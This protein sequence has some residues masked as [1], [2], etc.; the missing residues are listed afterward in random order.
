LPTEP[1]PEFTGGTSYTGLSRRILTGLWIGALLGVLAHLWTPQ[2]EQE[3]S[4][5]IWCA[6]HV[7][8]PFGQIFL[9]MI[10]MVVLPLVVSALILGISEL[11]ESQQVGRLGLA[12]LLLT[13]TLS[14]IAVGL[15]LSLANALEPGGRLDPQARLQLQKRYGHRAL[16]EHDSATRPGKSWTQVLV[17]LLPENPLQEM[18]GALDGSSKGNGMLAVM[19][20]ALL[21]GIALTRLG[22]RAD[23]LRQLLDVLFR[24]SM[25]LVEWA[26]KL[27]PYGVAALAFALTS[28]LGL[29]IVAPLAWYVATVLLGL[30]LQLLVVYPAVLWT[31]ARRSPRWFFQRS[32]EALVTAFATASSNATL[33]VT[34]HVA[35]SSLAIPSPVARFV[36]T[37]GATG[38]QNGT[39]LYE[40]VTVLFL[41]QVF[42]VELSLPQQLTVVLMCI[43]AGVGTAGVPG[44]SLPLVAAICRSVNIPP[45]GIAIILGVDRVLDMCRTTL[46]V[47]G[48]LTIA[49]CVAR[50]APGSAQPNNASEPSAPTRVQLGPPR[51]RS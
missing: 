44:G 48:D 3:E 23:V 38:N 32:S 29:E 34:L 22:P 39:A 15:G 36:L 4:L 25:V 11:R 21:F 26:M 24:A 8:R 45:E 14:T 2:A 10:F 49:L 30:A 12:T 16:A 42:G 27:A 35:E 9:R 18:V 43:L 46:N 5:L 37:L 41:A 50:L 19:V 7:A 40:G 17:D 6:E 47:A 20:F 13:V 28:Q 33:P 1:T 51:P 31:L